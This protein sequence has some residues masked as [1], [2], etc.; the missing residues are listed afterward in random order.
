MS[1]Y[2]SILLSLPE[3]YNEPY[4]KLYPGYVLTPG[5]VGQNVTDLQTYLS[6]IAE[7]TGTLP[8]ITVDGIYGDNTR[9]AVYTFQAQNNLPVTGSVGPATWYTITKAYNEI[10]ESRL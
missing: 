10:I 5:A 1:V 8:P 3:G 7:A 6:V 2:G 4:A 9:D